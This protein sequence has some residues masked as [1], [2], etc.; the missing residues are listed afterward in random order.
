MDLH[1][2]SR[3]LVVLAFAAAFLVGFATTAKAVI[4]ISSADIYL[5]GDEEPVG[6]LGNAMLSIGD[7]IEVRVVVSSDTSIAYVFADM[8]KYGG[9]TAE[10]LYT[11]QG[12]AAHVPTG[13]LWV[14][15]CSDDQTAAY[16]NSFSIVYPDSPFVL[17]E[18]W[19]VWSD[20]TVADAWIINGNITGVL[21]DTAW[22]DSLCLITDGTN[23]LFQFEIHEL[24]PDTLCCSSMGIICDHFVFDTNAAIAG[25]S[26][27]R[28]TLIVTDGGI[29]WID[30]TPCPY[31][32]HADPTVLVTA[33]DDSGLVDTLRSNA[34]REVVTD[35][36]VHFDTHHTTYA[37]LIDPGG[38]GAEFIEVEDY[39]YGAMT[40]SAGLY[41]TFGWPDNYLNPTSLFGF[42]PDTLYTNLDMRRLSHPNGNDDIYHIYWDAHVAGFTYADTSLANVDSLGWWIVKTPYYDGPGGFVDCVAETC[43]YWEVWD[44]AFPIMPGSTDVDEGIAQLPMKWISDSGDTTYF[45]TFTNVV[46]AA[47]D[48]IIPDATDTLAAEPDTVTVDDIVFYADM[49]NAGSPDVLNPASEGYEIPDWLQVQIDLAG[50]YDLDDITYGFADMMSTGWYLGVDTPLGLDYLAEMVTPP[51]SPLAPMWGTDLV[52]ILASPPSPYGWDQDTVSTQVWLFDDAGNGWYVGPKDSAIGIDNQIP[53]IDPDSCIAYGYIYVEITEDVALYTGYANVGEPTDNIYDENGNSDP[54]DDYTTRDK[55]VAHANL[56]DA[57]GV[58]EV[59]EVWIIDDPFC[60]DSLILYDDGTLGDDPIAGDKNYT[61]HARVEVG[62]GLFC[63]LDTDEDSVY[64]SVYMSDNS[65]NAAILT[66]CL[67]VKYD[68]EIPTISPENVA[69]MFWDDPEFFGV[70]GDING[71]GIVTYGDSLIFEWRAED[72][73][74]DDTE[75]D[76]VRVNAASIDPMYSGWITLYWNPSGGIYRNHWPDGPGAP[77]WVDY[78]SV[79]G[80]EL[81]ADFCVWDNA[82]NST[83]WRNFCSG[84]TLDNI[85]TMISC[86]D[87]GITISGEDDLAT[88]GDTITFTYTGPTEGI[89]T[90]WIDVIDLHPSDPTY[91]AL[92]AGNSWSSYFVVQAGDIDSVAY[93]FDVTA[94][95]EVGN[96][97]ACVTDPIAVDNQAPTI[98]CGYAYLRLFDYVDNVPTPIVNVG[99]N[100]TAVFFDR[101]GDIVRVTADFSNYSD[102]IGVVEMV[103]GFDGGPEYKWGYRVDPV[104][105]G[106]IDQQPGGLGTLVLIT[107]Y[108]DVGNSASAWVCP[109]HF[110]PETYLPDPVANPA[111]TT[112][113]CNSSC[114]GVDTE[115]PEP[116]DPGSITFTLLETS[117]NIAN[118]GDRLHIVVDMGDPT[119][120]GYDMQWS[121]S[122]LEADIGQYGFDYEGNYIQLVDDGWSAG[123]EGDGKFSCFFFFDEDDGATWFDGYPILPG[124][125][126]LEA[127]SEGTKIRIRTRDDAGNY[128]S[129]WVWSDSLVHDDTGLPVPVDNEI[130]V[131]DPEDIS[132]SFVDMDDN[133]L[134]DIGDTVTISI[135]MTDAAGGPVAGVYAYLYDWGYPSKDM[136]PLAAQSPVYTITFPVQQNEGEYCDEVLFEDEWCIIL[137]NLAVPPGQPHPSVQ[138]LAQD[139]SDNWSNYYWTGPPAYFSEP[140]VQDW[141]FEW[142]WPTGVEM[143]GIVADT[144]A[145]D[146]VNPTFEAN[147]SGV[148]AEQLPEGRIGIH[149]FYQVTPRNLDVDEFYVYGDLDTPGEVDWTTYLG[150]PIPAGMVLENPSGFGGDYEWISDM[151]P[152]R[153]E[154]YHFGILAV[155]NA[156]NMSDPAQT[157]IAGTE[158]DVDYPTAYVRAVFGDEDYPCAAPGDST[159]IGN[160]DDMFLAYIKEAEEFQNV[161]YVELYARVTDLDP[162]TEG[163]QPGMWRMIDEVGQ[164]PAS[165]PLPAMP[166]EFEVDELSDEFEP[167]QC[168]TYDVIAVP[169]DESGN[170]P[171]IAECEI[172][173]F[174]YD[175]W[176]PLVTE[177][178]INGISSPHNLELSGSADIEINA[179]DV[180]DE[181]TEL[182]YWLY[183]S[184]AGGQWLGDDALLVRETVPAG[185]PFTYEWDI[186]NY[187]QGFT[188]LELY[189]CD[190]AGNYSHHW[191]QV[192]VID[193]YAPGGRFATV[194]EGGTMSHPEYT[195]LTD[196]MM[197]GGSDMLPLMFWVQWPGAMP[198]PYDVGQVQVDYMVHGATEDWHTIAIVT[199]YGPTESWAGDIWYPYYFEFD[200]SGFSDGDQID[201]RATVMDKR[202][203]TEVVVITVYIASEAPI[204]TIDVPEAM[205]V[206]GEMRVK[207]QFNVTATETGTIPIDTYNIYWAY[208]RSSDPD[209]DLD[210]DWTDDDGWILHDLE[211]LDDVTPETIWRT[212]VDPSSEGMEDGSWDFVVV[213]VDVAGNWSWDINGDGCIDAGYFAWAVDH[214]M[215]MT[216]VLQNE[217]PEV[218]IRSVN[219]FEPVDQGWEW[220]I[221]VYVQVGDDVTVTSWTES[222]CDVEKVEYWLYGEEVVNEPI[223][224]A[225]STDETSD[226]EAMFTALSDY[227]TPDAL[228]DGF[229]TV[230]LV[231]KLTDVLGNVYGTP[232]GNANWVDLTIIDISPTSAFVTSPVASSCVGHAVPLEATVL[233]GDEVY[234]VTYEYRAVGTQDWNHIATTRPHDGAPWDTD[235]NNDQIYWYTDIL[236]DGQYELRAVSRDANL[237]TDPAPPVITVWVDNTAPV[238]SSLTLDPSVEAGGMTWIGGP[239]VEMTAEVTDG[240]CGL[241]QVKFWY[242]PMDEAMGAATLIYTDDEAPFAYMWD[243]GFT[244]LASG[245]YDLVVEA[246]DVAGNTGW[247]EVTVYV[248]QWAPDGWIVQINDDATP[249][250]SAFYGVVT[251]TGMCVDDVPDGQYINQKYDS[252]LWGAQFQIRPEEGS[253]TNFGGLVMGSGPTYDLVFDTGLLAPGYYDLRIVGIDNVGNR[254]DDDGVPVLDYI[255]IEIIGGPYVIAGVDNQ[256]DY[257]LAYGGG[258]AGRVTFEY[259]PA[260]GTE[261]WH[262]IGTATDDLGDGVYGVWWDFSG[263]SGDFLLRAVSSESGADPSEMTVTIAGGTASMHGSAHI[264]S[265]TRWGNLEDIDHVTVGVEADVR[266]TVIVAYDA[267][268]DVYGDAP[269]TMLLDVT[270]QGDPPMWEDWFSVY[271]VDLGVWTIIASYDDTGTVGATDDVVR[272]FKVTEEEGSNGQVNQDGMWFTLASGGWDGGDDGL[273]MIMIP[274]PDTDPVINPPVLV[275]D[276][277]MMVF[278]YEGFECFDN[279]MNADVSMSYDT[280]SIPS[281]FAEGDLRVARLYNGAWTYSGITDV[282]VDEGANKVFFETGTAGVYA[283]V[284]HSTLRIATPVFMPRCGD[285]TGPYM[286]FCSIIED[287]LYGVNSAEIRVVLD[288]PAEDPIFDMMKIYDGGS[289]A[290]GFDAY[291]DNTANTLCVEV[292]DDYCYET[293]KSS[294]DDGWSGIGLPGGTY[295]LHIWAMNGAGETK[296]L[297]HTFMVDATAPTIA[298]T[299]KDGAYVTVKTVDTH[300]IFYLMIDDDESGV[301]LD[302]VYIDVFVVD[303]DAAYGEHVEDEERLGT[304]TPSAMTYDPVTGLLIADFGEIYRDDLPEG[305]SLDVVVYNGHF[306]NCVDDDCEYGDCRCYYNGD[307]VADCAGNN[308]T[309]VWRRFTVKAEEEPGPI[310][311]TDVKSYPNPFDPAGGECATISM[312]LSKGAHVMIKVYDFAGEHVITIADDWYGSGEHLLHWCG[313]DGN[314]NTVATG[315]YIGYVRIDDNMKVFTKT[316][317]IGV[318]NGGND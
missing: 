207:G 210:C 277:V 114:V 156:G 145:P 117:N 160:D 318:V 138:A 88:I 12:Q 60:V 215:G 188:Q 128:S 253:W 124:E 178:A 101:Y 261:D 212:T 35:T 40:D 292:D 38:V 158:A 81:C 131:I 134:L 237:I 3:K 273:L 96:E 129:D 209:V 49:D 1:S 55:I 214:D 221:P 266:P 63:H 177:F 17:T 150:A 199:N 153:E 69:I 46:D 235:V 201:L 260:G 47:I 185:D 310:Y 200:T 278:T 13:I 80:E 197:I 73:V 220:P 142:A 192:V 206:C 43:G 246:K 51:V 140:Y 216:I 283:V 70:E 245:W 132:A 139:S 315:A 307:G 24:V 234:D 186:T 123:G 100:L 233:A 262:V 299:D 270:T 314:G 44:Y 211:V 16:M 268:P 195:R 26:T 151:L 169:W 184:R 34:P 259:S 109:I 305:L 229:A 316:L 294:Y 182:T 10:T 71:D 251:F 213:T 141:P 74:W 146:P 93:T 298:F 102:S 242:K 89:V 243:N 281:G 165:Y 290:N 144:D 287:D 308:A 90:I 18:H 67:G 302:E 170:H 53:Y 173:V 108:D 217:A 187:P 225:M 244:S 27:Y 204:L 254:A 317:K 104:P 8:C 62:N 126:N 113:G 92:D 41:P 79:D 107:A 168:T 271:D 172:F 249:D 19:E 2:M 59:D 83:G 285:Y 232:Y 77:Y 171:E 159:V 154:P 91:V 205:E 239:F 279:D 9:S 36:L 136:V 97:F 189:V 176:E 103:Y 224:V 76:S 291:Y 180:C 152:E 52:D 303:P 6:A 252:G 258:A 193:E 30:D 87:I 179:N 143:G 167:E 263:L 297:E 289:V 42:A 219:D 99:D 14:P 264:T 15:S 157:W 61:G 231:A 163:N 226:Y 312:K 250:G 98:G 106:L 164:Y 130:P 149:L 174:T 50:L 162:G 82:G 208:K 272:V 78:G 28:D 85:G 196:G 68:N 276:A 265:L 133:G 25:D 183:L 218:R 300:P 282:T 45:P 223:L 280:A 105:E 112:Y 86:G 20:T 7:T 66:S 120:P 22:T 301:D 241:D 57:F 269:Q 127:G 115:P 33:M 95:D 309:P 238:I 166:Y 147:F 119:A 295:D 32:G 306:T 227:L 202:G 137:R 65:G 5:I 296:Y 175:A 84:L 256:T 194:Q 23:E 203:N 275:S 230:T 257:V 39:F 236:A 125:A 4:T 161:C 11:F 94:E 116:P 286:R 37:Q 75:I 190:V 293:L 228:V 313:G 48:N 31:I 72:E 21:P 58:D 122:I 255:T 148:K 181:T 191:K 118:V 64:F 288:G 54:L 240:E 29:C 284:A 121:T 274:E 267:A 222:D 311:V 198:L 111:D 155:D 110:L 56:G 247:Y 135:D 248:D 304:I